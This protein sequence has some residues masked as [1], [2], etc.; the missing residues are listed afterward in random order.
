MYYI[1]TFGR[2]FYPKQITAFSGMQV[3]LGNVKV[4]EHPKIKI[5]PNLYAFLLI[6]K[7]DI[8]ENVGNKQ[9]L[10]L[11]TFIIKKYIEVSGN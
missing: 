10:F 2:H 6:M 3:T 11:L 7:E 8:L 5:I 9:F 4:I 1:Y